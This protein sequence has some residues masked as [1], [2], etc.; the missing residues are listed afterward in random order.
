MLLLML[1]LLLHV[2]AAA[3]VGGGVCSRALQ[4]IST[5]DSHRTEDV[6]KVHERLL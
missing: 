1:M 6:I 5:Y 2:A 4:T 3:V